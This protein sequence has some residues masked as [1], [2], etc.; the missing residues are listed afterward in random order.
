MFKDSHNLSSYYDHHY[1]NYHIIFIIRIIIIIII[2]TIIIIIL[3]YHHYYH[4][5]HLIHNLKFHLSYV[6]YDIYYGQVFH[7]SLLF[8]FYLKE[9]IREFY[10]LL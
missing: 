5:H 8:Q 2:I 6:T 7:K 3:F 10:L 4:Y 9:T 1:Y